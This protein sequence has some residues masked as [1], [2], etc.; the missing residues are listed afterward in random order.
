[1]ITQTHKRYRIHFFAIAV[2]LCL[3]YLFFGES[4]DVEKDDFLHLLT[5]LR[6][7]K[8]LNEELNND[9]LLAH[10]NMLRNYEPLVAVLGELEK[11]TADISEDVY[12][13]IDI[14]L[15]IPMYFS[16]KYSEYSVLGEQLKERIKKQQV[17]QIQRRNAVENFKTKNSMLK[18]SRNYLPVLEEELADGLRNSDNKENADEDIKG[19][20]T[21]MLLF[22]IDYDSRHKIIISESRNRL[23][24]KI[25]GLLPNEQKIL[26]KFFTHLD[27]I[28]HNNDEVIN[29]TKSL[30]ADGNKENIDDIY[31]MISRRYDILKYKDDCFTTALFIISL[32]LIVYVLVMLSRLFKT[33]GILAKSNMLLEN[34]NTIRDE[35]EQTLRRYYKELQKQQVELIEAKEDAERANAAKSDFLANMSHEI[36]TPMNGVLGMTGLL[37]DTELNDEQR[38]WAEVIRKSGENLMEIINDILDFSKIEAGQLALEPIAFDI[39]AV[40]MEV[41]DLLF[42]RTQEKGIGLLVNIPTD[43]P[44]YVKTDLTRLRQVL[45]NLSGNAIKFTEKGHVLIEVSW[46]K[47]EDGNI[48]LHFDIHDTGIGIP[49]DKIGYIFDKFSQAEESTTRRFGGTGLG[50]AICSKLV[51]MM[52]GKVIVKSEIGKGSVFS[53][54]II[55]EP[56]PQL[57]AAKSLIPDCELEG[58]RVLII[59]DSETSQ[60]ILCQYLTAWKMRCDLADTADKATALIEGSIAGKAPYNF[61]LINY[62]MYRMHGAS[63]NSMADWDSSSAIRIALGQAVT[64]ENMV[65]QGFAAFL[66]KPIYPNH[67]KAVLQLL[68]DA[69]VHG[70]QLPLVTRHMVNAMLRTKTSDENI[71]R[72]MF[73][74]ARVLVAED[75][76][77]NT[78]LI[79]KMLKN[80]G[81]EVFA[82]ENGHDAVEAVRKENYDIVFMDCQM[83]GMDGF[84][85]T[86]EIRKMEGESRHTIIVALT[87][88]AMIGDREKCLNAG[89]DDYLN[90]PLRP[91]KL[92]ECLKKWLYKAPL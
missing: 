10:N 71:S 12:E 31:Q 60:K 66:V 42:L 81:C 49:A 54:D 9:V 47:N 6:T 15:T 61:I 77:I 29:I 58:F 63:N 5:D 4:Q 2:I 24:G 78:M 36:R 57:Q 19:I 34:A 82:V 44:L 13:I 35:K 28:L 20:F 75:V 84:E 62:R 64:S 56:V 73:A 83:P 67:L 8:H 68:W 92:T 91:Q 59:D 89:M 25:S 30:L 85:A 70:K 87:A 7:M 55:A 22:L 32:L 65:Q 48:V 90:K 21:E 51:G 88:D 17:I 53:F 23:N 37:L 27:I 39:T 50:L 33:V 38:G 26:G 11:I 1:M 41:T 72:N 52:G 18:N 3:V 14:P 40:I 46:K 76:K 74:G 86:H 80:H 69:K 79:T 43:L 45:L 16:P